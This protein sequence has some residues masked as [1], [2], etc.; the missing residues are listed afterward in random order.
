[1][2]KLKL[3]NTNT[4]QAKKKQLDWQRCMKKVGNLKIGSDRHLSFV[5]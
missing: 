3:S 2:Q 4:L 1:M 5:L